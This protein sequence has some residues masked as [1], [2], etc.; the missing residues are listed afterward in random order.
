M[1][2]ILLANMNTDKSQSY[3]VN[4]SHDICHRN[5]PSATVP[6]RNG[7]P[8]NEKSVV[9]SWCM[10]APTKK[11]IMTYGFTMTHVKKNGSINKQI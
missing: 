9:T 5:S 11:V 10:E 7:S 3:L 6:I 4:L 2:K 8:V 1:S